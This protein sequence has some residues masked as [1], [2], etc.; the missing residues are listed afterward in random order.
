MLR[1]SFRSRSER[2]PHAGCAVSTHLSGSSGSEVDRSP[3]LDGRRWTGDPNA[4]TRDRWA[5]K[6]VSHSIYSI[7]THDAL[8][9]PPVSHASR[10]V[11]RHS[12]IG[13]AAGAIALRMLLLLS[14]PLVGVSNSLAWLY[15]CD[16]SL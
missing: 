1:P 14:S 12:G 5:N 16:I 8:R 13:R 7:H 10:R 9:L 11:R 3:Q 15:L 2:N 4:R 6:I